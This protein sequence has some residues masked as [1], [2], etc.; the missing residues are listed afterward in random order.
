LGRDEPSISMDS[1]GKII[2]AKQ[3]DIQTTNVKASIG[4][5]H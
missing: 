3:T 4:K 5:L 2:W 1:S